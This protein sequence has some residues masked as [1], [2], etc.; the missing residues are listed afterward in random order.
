MVGRVEA[1]QGRTVDRKIAAVVYQQNWPV[2]AVNATSMAI[3]MIEP[4][5]R[6]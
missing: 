6:R 4:R 2:G 5:N 1:A 3:T